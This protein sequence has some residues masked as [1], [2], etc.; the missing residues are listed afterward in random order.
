MDWPNDKEAWKG[1]AMIVAIGFLAL[2]GAGS[3]LRAIFEALFNL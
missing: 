1:V 2:W 3:I